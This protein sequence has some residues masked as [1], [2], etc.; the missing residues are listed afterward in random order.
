MSNIDQS[1][2]SIYVLYVFF[3]NLAGGAF[4]GFL[5]TLNGVKESVSEASAADVMQKPKYSNATAKPLLP[6]GSSHI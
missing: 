4:G 2:T 6:G 3:S 1:P 5:Q